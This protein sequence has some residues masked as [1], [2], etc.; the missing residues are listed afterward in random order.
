MGRN[1]IDRLRVEMHR[2]EAKLRCFQG[3][4]EVLAHQNRMWFACRNAPSPATSTRSRVCAASQSQS[5]L[6]NGCDGAAGCRGVYLC[7]GMLE[8]TSEGACDSAALLDWHN[9]I[10]LVQRKNGELPNSLFGRS[11]ARAHTEF[12]SKRPHLR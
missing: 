2:S 6:D 9:Q 10:L 11:A 4:M 1:G 3:R 5:P 8:R 12:W 7:F